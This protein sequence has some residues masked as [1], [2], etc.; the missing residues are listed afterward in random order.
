MTNEDASAV[1]PAFGSLADA[2]PSADIGYSAAGAGD[3]NSWNE[4]LSVADD[5]TSLGI[6]AM[7]MLHFAAANEK[8]LLT[9]EGAAEYLWSAF[10]EPLQH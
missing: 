6:R 8:K 2:A 9:Q 7:G 10:I 4:S 3:R 5:G 1:G